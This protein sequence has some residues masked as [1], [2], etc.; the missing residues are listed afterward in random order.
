MPTPGVDPNVSS[1][2]GAT[3]DGQPICYHR[4]PS[5]DLAPWIGRLYVARDT[6]PAGYV[7]SCGLLSDTATL[8]I[9]VDGYWRGET[10]RGA[11]NPSSP[12]MFVGPNSR[13]MPVTSSGTYVGLGMSMRP[14]ACHM[15]GGP[16]VASIVDSA[17]PGE[18]VGI[19]VPALM[20]QF[21]EDG[22][23][24]EWLAVLE[25]MIRRQVADRK[26]LPPS[27]V[28]RMFER[29]SFERP[30]V[31]VAEAAQ[32]CCVDRRKLERIVLRD[33]GLSPKQVLRRAR[34]LDM[35]AFLRGVSDTSEGE[36]F[37]LRYYDDSH[38]I[39]EF[40]ELF[41]MPPSQFASTPQPL[42]TIALESRQ[43]RRLET[44]E[45]IEPGAN[46]PWL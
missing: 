15:L 40:V 36:E 22:S 46:R 34:A 17:V 23:P 24:E 44:L 2:Y 26:A 9:E 33:F 32:I 20:A 35:A 29:L 13:R 27:P 4:A 12:V 28:T 7:M 5:P 43:A 31:T 14:G 30:S 10:G 19:D 11:L 18:A 8:R 39:H 6:A 41:G 38:L 37:A 42:M 3:R 45:R 1:E 21:A 16:R 25:N